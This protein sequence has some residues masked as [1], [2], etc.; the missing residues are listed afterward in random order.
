[1][2]A[3]YSKKAEHKISKVMKEGYSGK[4]HASSKKGPLVKN[5]KQMKA[6]ALSESR[7]AGYKTPE[8]T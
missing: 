3:K 6:I 2:S 7:R 1:M 4:L 5:P 8:R